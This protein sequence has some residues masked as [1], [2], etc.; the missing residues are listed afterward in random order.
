MRGG[1]RLRGVDRPAGRVAGRAGALACAHLVG[2]C[3]RWW[4]ARVRRRGAV[5]R[6]AAPQAASPPAASIT[7]AGSIPRPPAASHHHRRHR[8]PFPPPHVTGAT[9]DAGSPWP[10]RRKPYSRHCPRRRPHVR[11]SDGSGGGE[12]TAAAAVSA[13][14]PTPAG[15][16]AA[17]LPRSPH[18]HRR[19]RCPPHVRHHQRHTASGVAP[20]HAQPTIVM[21]FSFVHIFVDE[22]QVMESFAHV[23]RLE[24]AVPSPL[25]APPR[26]CSLPPL[27]HTPTPPKSPSP[28]PLP[29]LFHPTF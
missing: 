24:R 20:H 28:Y 6:G 8:R 18:L 19:R 26:L 21:F 22:Q 9:A 12:L 13:P 25:P 17:V 7:G 15:Q 3:G 4:G 14:L 27:P 16:T 11:S 1:G 23:N 5:A 29:S 2:V 10:R